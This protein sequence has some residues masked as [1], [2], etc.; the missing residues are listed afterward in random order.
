MP[1]IY[2]VK[3]GRIVTNVICAICYEEDGIVPEAE[4]RASQNIGGKTPLPVCR[5]CF[6]GKVDILTSGCRANHK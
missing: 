6:D 4:I 5:H 1:G 3:G 2:G